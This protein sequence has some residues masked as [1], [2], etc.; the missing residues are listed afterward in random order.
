MLSN[1]VGLCEL[2][3]ATGDRR[4]LE[5]VL[6][7][8]QD[9]VDKRLYLTGT[10]QPV[11]AFPG[12]PRAAA[13]TPAA[14]IGETCV[15]TTWIQLNLQL[16]R[17]TGEAKFGD[18]LER[19]FYNH[20]AA[21]QHPRGRR[22]VLLH[23]L[24][25]PQALRQGDQL[26]PFQRPARHGPGAAGGV[27]ARPERRRRAA[28]EHAG[29]VACHAGTRRP[30]VTVDQQSGFP[31][32]GE[33]V[34]DAAHG[35]AGDVRRQVRVPA[36]AA[37]LTLEVD[38]RSTDA[39][40]VGPMCRPGSGKTAT[41]SS[42]NSI[43]PRGSCRPIRQRRAG[44]RSL[45]TVRAGL[46]PEAEPGP[47]APRALGLVESQPPFALE[48]GDGL[49]FG[50]QVV[51]RAAASRERRRWSRSPTRGPTAAPIASGSAHRAW[52]RRQDDSLLADGRES[53]SRHGQRP[54]SI[55]D[56]D[57]GS[58]VVTFD[59]RPAK[60]DWYAVTL[61]AP[62][63]IRRVV[64][65]HGRNFH[66]GG[67]FERCRQAEGASAADE[68]G[69][70]GDGRRAGRLPGRRQRGRL[71]PG[72]KFTL[73]L[74]EPVEPWPCASSA[75]RPAATIRIRRSLRAP[76][77]RRWP[78]SKRSRRPTHM[79]YYAD[80]DADEVAEDLHQA[81]ERWENGR[82]GKVLGKTDD[83]WRDP[84]ALESCMAAGDK[85]P[86]DIENFLPWNLSDHCRQKLANR[87]SSVSRPD[88]S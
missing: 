44:P 11:G 5:A 33:S 2:A 28:G 70:V 34:L 48:A 47:A 13:T 35:A 55:N 72:Q 58:I 81:H 50:A 30:G 57:F 75:C 16:L 85:P 43:S 24:G 1:L 78:N 29:D 32:R 31:R 80:L 82:Q 15:T 61:D 23:A 54:G 45:G 51:G 83:S 65:A 4:M 79:A 6:N 10:R 66:D 41:A 22:L 56:G 21:A 84:A 73:R 64:F 62:V 87:P 38:G 9:I 14:N 77:S 42:S 52:P 18:E 88:T 69:R 8:W 46:R 49:A 53:R 60:E 26:L 76:S 86:A 63:T 27:F 17:L 68:G 7:A 19:A 39:A 20:L 3:R 71:K 67:W 25:R 59:G 37:P 74:A 12:R 36:W 40:G